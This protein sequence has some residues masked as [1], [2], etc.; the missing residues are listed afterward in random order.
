MGMIAI[1]NLLVKSFKESTSN[2]LWISSNNDSVLAGSLPCNPP[3][4][5]TLKLSTLLSPKYTMGICFS[6]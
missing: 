1:F 5:Q 2:K 4:K 3:I 6:F